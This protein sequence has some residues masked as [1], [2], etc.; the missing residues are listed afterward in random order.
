[1][2][3]LRCTFGRW[4]VDLSF[5]A[6]PGHVAQLPLGYL[7]P[8]EV[9]GTQKSVL[10]VAISSALLLFPRALRTLYCNT[11]LDWLWD[12]SR[13]EL[14]GEVVRKLTLVVPVNHPL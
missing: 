7:T 9:V 11:A 13:S 2:T 6:A 1:V 4:N 3:Y 5:K 12:C 8:G 10:V 14:V